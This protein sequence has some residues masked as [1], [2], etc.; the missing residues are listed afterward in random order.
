[1]L[2]GAKHVNIARS[3]GT[4]GR[5]ILTT[6]A[7]VL[8]GR[9][10]V[11][12]L[13]GG[14]CVESFEL[15]PNDQSFKYVGLSMVV[16]LLQIVVFTLLPVGL[17]WT[18]RISIV[19]GI[20]QILRLVS[21][22]STVGLPRQ[23]DAY[24]FVHCILIIVMYF[25]VAFMP[26]V[27][28]EN[29]AYSSYCN[30]MRTAQAT[31]KTRALVNILCAELKSPAQQTKQILNQVLVSLPS[32]VKQQLSV[33]AVVHNLASISMVVDNVLF[34]IR[35]HERRFRFSCRD[36]LCL[37]A[38]C[39]EVLHAVLHSMDSSAAPTAEDKQTAA[40]SIEDV[41]ELH[42]AMCTVHTEKHCF[43][44][45]LFHGISAIYLASRSYSSQ[46]PPSPDEL[47]PSNASLRGTSESISSVSSSS[48]AFEVNASIET[49]QA[50]QWLRV[51]AK[52][53]QG[54]GRCPEGDARHHF[55]SCLRFCQR[56]IAAC[57][58]EFDCS[59]ENASIDFAMPCLALDALL[60]NHLSQS[61]LARPLPVP[62]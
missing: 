44:V 58:G 36:A 40:V 28:L 38:A 12:A 22:K 47:K 33:A 61:S 29:S 50:Q 48:R 9:I 16:D 10:V 23:F 35:L 11:Y 32:K 20:I 15:A 37:R 43:N 31:E 5:G 46:L 17:M 52:A 6:R 54:V 21:C 57:D 7:L 56:T 13:N 34:L 24:I 62:R 27:I 18:A 55:Q 1:M 26:A 59:I 53:T 49:R 2:F 42:A 14:T 19:E 41:F 4:L 3:L 45:L 25:M 39:E 51:T 60:A 8:T 30:V